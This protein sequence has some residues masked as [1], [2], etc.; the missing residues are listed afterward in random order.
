[1]SIAS[2]ETKCARFRE[3]CAGH[4][5]PVQRSAAPSSS[6]STGAPQTGQNCGK[7]YGFAPAGRLSSSTSRISGMISPAFRIFTVSPMR[8]SFSEIKS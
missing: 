6:R 4:S 2:R 8:T 1:M 5:A 3:S 7:K